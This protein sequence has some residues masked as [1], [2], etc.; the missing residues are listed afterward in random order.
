MHIL[1]FIYTYLLPYVTLTWLSHL[2][3][4]TF[5]CL[6]YIREAFC[7]SRSPNTTYKTICLKKVYKYSDFSMWVQE[8]IWTNWFISVKDTVEVLAEQLG[9]DESFN[10]SRFAFRLKET[11]FKTMLYNL[12]KETITTDDWTCTLLPR[13]QTAPGEDSSAGIRRTLTPLVLS[14]LLLRN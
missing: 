14:S 2:N 5:Y 7:F 10:L 8:S 12:L 4:K 11:L 6:K 1:N 3:Q 9:L 13:M